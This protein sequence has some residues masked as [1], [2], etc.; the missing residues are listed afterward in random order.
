MKFLTLLYSTIVFIF[1]ILSCTKDPVDIEGPS[2]GEEEEME[3]VSTMDTTNTTTTNTNTYVDE[4]AGLMKTNIEEYPGGID[5]RKIVDVASF[6]RINITTF[7]DGTLFA[8]KYKTNLHRDY[9]SI[10]ARRGFNDISEIY[11]GKYIIGSDR[12]GFGI[13]RL[14]PNEEFWS[15]NTQNP[16]GHRYISAITKLSNGKVI[17]IS[18]EYFLTGDQEIIEYNFIENTAK[19]IAFVPKNRRAEKLFASHEKDNTFYVTFQESDIIEKWTD[20][21]GFVEVSPLKGDLKGISYFKS[22]DGGEVSNIFGLSIDNATHIAVGDKTS[23]TYKLPNMG[24]LFDITHGDFDEIYISSRRG[25]FVFAIYDDGLVK[26]YNQTYGK[27]IA[28]A[29]EDRECMDIFVA[30]P[31][32]CIRMGYN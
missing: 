19:I 11:P 1:I 14:S 6:E 26:I 5:D 27:K 16:A 2:Q 22:E 17:A 30:G 12:D 28:Q 25:I 10:G 4:C 24:E 18:E 23:Y 20:S 9:T 31:S 21:E 32:G 13:L 29:S 8:F 3:V 7:D 15:F